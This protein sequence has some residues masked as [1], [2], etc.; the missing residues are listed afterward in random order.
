MNGR[1]VNSAFLGEPPRLRQI[2]VHRWCGA[3]AR[4]ET[5]GSHP[6]DQ[7]L[8]ALSRCQRWCRRR[9]CG[10]RGWDGRGWGDR[11]RRRRLLNRAG[12]RQLA[13]GVVHLRLPEQRH[14]DDGKAGDE[15]YQAGRG[16]RDLERRVRDR[17]PRPRTV[18]R[19]FCR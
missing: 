14:C 10:G 12:G 6:L 3:I 19:G 9:G 5:H 15:K 8:Q 4:G 18:L 16:R 17:I 1:V 7:R 11:G 2:R 13:I